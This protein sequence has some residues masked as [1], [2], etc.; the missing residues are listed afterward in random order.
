MALER[1]PRALEQRE[2]RHELDALK[3]QAIATALPKI[4][5][6]ASTLRSRNPGLLNSP[7]FASL[8]EG[9]G[10]GIDPSFLRPIPVTTYDY[11]IAL[12]QTIYSFGRVGAAINTARIRE[13]QI[14]EEI[15]ATEINIAR[16]AVVALYD[17]AVARAGLEVLA[18][19]RAALERQLRQAQDFLDTGAGTRLQLLQAQTALSALRPREISARG[20][21]ELAQAALNEA[22]GLPSEQAVT[23]ATGLLEAEALDE[24]PSREALRAATGRRPDLLA[25][26]IERRSL[27]EQSKVWRAN[28]LPDL[29]LSGAFG[30][31]TIFTE[32]LTNQDFANWN[33]GVFFDWSFYDGRQTHHK[34]AEIRSQQIQNEYRE[35]ALRAQHEREL[36][37][38]ITEYERA[39]EEAA[40]ARESVSTAEETLRV[41]EDSYR[42][43]AATS[44]DILEAQQAL[45]SA[46]FQKLQAAHDALVAFVRIRALAGLFPLDS[47]EETK[48]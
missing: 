7:N 1:H 34:L 14:A 13:E 10:M 37:S 20:K 19:E 36:V 48:P 39:R 22:L 12:E 43:G 23:P 30:I 9:G 24:L 16:D 41:A 32:E 6:H 4:S 45:T 5:A 2:R 33:I 18:S 8:A 40:A 17:L 27:G 46:R 15:R 3:G 42:W 35:R 38:R 21:V 31:S 11:N 26:K 29:K 28:T 47:F 44:L 25:M